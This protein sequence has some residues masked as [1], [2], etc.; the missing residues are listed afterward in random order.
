M[1]L[2]K[3]TL[4]Y[5]RAIITIRLGSRAVLIIDEMYSKIDITEVHRMQISNCSNGKE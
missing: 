4:I 1:E 5:H 3:K 2:H